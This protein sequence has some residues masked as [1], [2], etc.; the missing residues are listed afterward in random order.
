MRAGAP[1]SSSPPAATRTASSGSTGRDVAARREL[2]RPG[3]RAA[4]AAALDRLAVAAEGLPVVSSAL[5][6]LLGDPDL[7]WRSLA[8][9]LLAD[10]LADQ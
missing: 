3:R 4:L 2:D 10:E 6:A 8:L 7:A 1:C 9:A 5:R